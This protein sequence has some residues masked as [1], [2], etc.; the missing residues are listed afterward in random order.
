MHDAQAGQQ[1][2]ELLPTLVQDTPL[3]LRQ[4]AGFVRDPVGAFFQQRLK[5][6]FDND[7]LTSRDDET[8]QLDGLEN[9]QHQD[10]LSQA[11]KRWV[12]EDY[13]PEQAMIELDLHV[14]RLQREGKLP[15]GGFG[16]LSASALVEAMPDM[17]ARYHAQLQAW[18]EIEEGQTATTIAADETTPGLSDWLGGIRRTAQGERAYLQLDSKKL[19]NA[20]S[21]RWHNLVRPWLR[22][23]ALQLSGQGCTTILVS[24]NGDVVFRPVPVQQAQAQLHALLDAWVAGMREPLPVACKSAFAWLAAGGEGSDTA[25]DKAREAFEGG[26]MHTG[27]AESSFALR[28]AYIDFDQLCASGQFPLWATRLYGGLF[29]HL[30]SSCAGSDQ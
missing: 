8:F 10:R 4:L 27:E 26:F 16:R 28:R 24:L 21:W 7:E 22:H 18:P 6:N 20:D 23:L 29:N 11:L 30:T 9:W 1:A 13:R 25:C 12:E 19:C 2:V 5:V 3:T 14:Q 15:L 17:L